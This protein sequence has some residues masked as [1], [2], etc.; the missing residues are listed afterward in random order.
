MNRN[1]DYLTSPAPLSNPS[2]YGPSHLRTR[3][4]PL[5]TLSDQQPQGHFSSHITKNPMRFRG[6]YEDR[7]DRHL[8]K[9]H[10]R[11]SEFLQAANPV[12]IETQDNSR[13]E[14][15]NAQNERPP[16]LPKLPPPPSI[17]PSLV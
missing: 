14:G 15:F 2:P 8:D 3:S 17:H 10:H 1:G 9:S 5:S 7:S 16:T 6:Q 13:V 12:L 11:R 4:I